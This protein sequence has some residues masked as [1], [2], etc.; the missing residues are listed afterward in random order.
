[1]EGHRPADSVLAELAVDSW[2]FAKDYAKVLLKID[3]NE[4]GRF[5]NK[6]LYYVE[7]LT[8]SLGQAGMK[9][10][11]LENHPFEMG[12]AAD[13]LNLDEF[14]TDDVLVVDQMLEPIIIGSDGAVVRTGKIMVRKASQ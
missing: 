3:A 14:S 12:M 10:V 11:N 8:S 13:V 5:A 1:M 6:L 9:I 2:R 7:R 4:Q